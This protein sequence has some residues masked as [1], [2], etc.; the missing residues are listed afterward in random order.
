MNSSEENQ[1]NTENN[2][3]VDKNKLSDEDA[4]E[5]A[6]FLI[7]KLKELKLSIS[8]NFVKKEN[9]IQDQLNHLKKYNDS[10]DSNIIASLFSE[11]LHHKKF[12]SWNLNIL[13]FAFLIK[14]CSSSSYFRLFSLL[15]KQIPHPETVESHFH[16]QIIKREKQLLNAN[17][18]NELLDQYL[19]DINEQIKNYI[20][21]YN[22]EFHKNISYDTFK[23]NVCLGC[24]AA[25]LTPFTNKRK[26]N[27]KKKKK[28]KKETQVKRKASK[29]YYLKNW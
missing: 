18:V 9:F 11:I 22:K 14:Y 4:C 5:F 28:K 8:E 7:A 27:S 20:N 23:I 29:S 17:A 2:S 24:D 12:E 6:F 15:N 3:H 13:K 10:N 16:Q 21:L 25:S 1:N 19:I 26:K